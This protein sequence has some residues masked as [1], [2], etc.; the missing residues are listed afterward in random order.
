VAKFRGTDGYVEG[1]GRL[2]ILKDGSDKYAVENKD[3][4]KKNY[5]FILA[6]FSNSC[7]MIY[8]FPHLDFLLQ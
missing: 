2:R 7:S 6:L 5:I 3:V 4:F 8:F 1:D